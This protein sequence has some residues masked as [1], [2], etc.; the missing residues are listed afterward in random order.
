M[1]LESLGHPSSS[2]PTKTAPV[3]H[4]SGHPW[5]VPTIHQPSCQ[6]GP[7][8]KHA[9]MPLGSTGFSSSHPTRAAPVWIKPWPTPALGL[10]IL[11]GL[12]QYRAPQDLLAI[13]NSAPAIQGI[14]W[15]TGS[16]GSEHI[17]E[18]GII[19]MPEYQEGNHWG[20]C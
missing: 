9:G 4:T 7:G 14:S 12:Q 6:G 8:A 11:L 5:A 16:L 15:R 13:P 3:W 2:H 20:P 19:Q 10:A 17:Q 1:S 18:E